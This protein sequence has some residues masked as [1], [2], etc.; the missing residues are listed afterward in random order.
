MDEKP[1]GYKPFDTDAYLQFSPLERIVR[2]KILIPNHQLIK[3]PEP[4]GIDLLVVNAEGIQGGIEVESHEKYWTKEFPFDTVHF[5][6]RKQKYTGENNFYLMCSKNNANAVVIN[7][8]RLTDDLRIINDNENCIE[9]P[10]YDVPR[11]QCVFGWTAIAE[12]LD[13]HFNRNK[14][15]ENLSEWM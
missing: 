3:N 12:H 2:T 4:Y 5:L 10:M 6:G 13:S 11:D 15:P 7:F 1:T 8:L 14:E 9:E